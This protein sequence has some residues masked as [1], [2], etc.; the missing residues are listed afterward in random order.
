[1]TRYSTAILALI[2]TIAIL[3]CTTVYAQ[4]HY[5]VRTLPIIIG[6]S[7][8]TVTGVVLC[9]GQCNAGDKIKIE[10][11]PGQTEYT[12]AS[13]NT[14]IVDRDRQE[15][16]M[17]QIITTPA[18]DSTSFELPITTLEPTGYVAFYSTLTFETKGKKNKGLFTSSFVGDVIV[19]YSKTDISKEIIESQVRP[20]S[21]PAI[22]PNSDHNKL[23]V[24]VPY[25]EIRAVPTQL[26]VLLED[27][28]AEV[29]IAYISFYGQL[30]LIYS[31]DLPEESV[32]LVNGIDVSAET[33][34]Q[35]DPETNPFKQAVHTLRIDYKKVTGKS[36]P[37]KT[38]VL[39]S[40]EFHTKQV[41]PTVAHLNTS[42]IAVA[43][44]K[45]TTDE[46]TPPYATYSGL[47]F[48]TYT[49][50]APIIS[51]NSFC[52]GNYLFH[53]ITIAYSAPTSIKG[54]EFA[55]TIRGQSGTPQFGYVYVGNSTYV[56]PE[57]GMQLLSS[58]IQTKK[59]YYN[60]HTIKTSQHAII[61][62]FDSN[63]FVSSV[64]TIV[65][66]TPT[67]GNAN[68]VAQF[69]LFHEF[70][71]D[72][73]KVIIPITTIATPTVINKALVTYPQ[74]D[75]EIRDKLSVHSSQQQQ[76][77]QHEYPIVDDELTG[78]H[79][80]L[81]TQHLTA[82]EQIWA[83]AFDLSNPLKFTVDFRNILPN[84]KA[85]D[86]KE[87]K[88]I[89]LSFP[90]QQFIF[91][92]DLDTCT[93]NN[94]KAPLVSKVEIPIEKNYY[95]KFTVATPVP[96]APGQQ[97]TLTCDGAYIIHRETYQTFSIL[98][99]FFPLQITTDTGFGSTTMFH[100]P[101]HSA[102]NDI[103][104]IIT[105]LGLGLLFIPISQLFLCWV[106]PTPKKALDN[107]ENLINAGLLSVDDGA[108]EDDGDSTQDRFSRPLHSVHR[109]LNLVTQS[110]DPHHN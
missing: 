81:Q 92:G 38:N 21:T 64:Y 102:R 68:S 3:F 7:T 47:V 43:L 49:R 15:I 28:T 103:I 94:I 66:A 16:V 27:I 4:D 8:A 110:E 82:D 50:D 57:T 96:L 31:G 46:K 42:Y 84:V 5:Y 33:T 78:Y 14:T 99:S 52:D 41:I 13:A 77:T 72:E 89:S 60:A 36:L 24:S 67:G 2:C 87:I 62:M 54:T 104:F 17:N 55:L 97:L 83:G 32:V 79:I 70:T 58:V 25:N 10:F 76:R 80:A 23:Q 40:F 95:V 100:Y 34:I 1:M 107:D 98:D 9:P 12:I 69:T 30:E 18:A 88:Q 44:K 37:Q 20:I 19:T 106:H 26:F 6:T 45:S 91:T 51:S 53:N 85:E 86:V 93:I 59:V 35:I 105:C 22:A 11:A 29:D 108:E 48:P 63:E 75:V 74:F 71:H 109:R 90:T 56:G 101:H 65:I 61:P 73:A 39:F